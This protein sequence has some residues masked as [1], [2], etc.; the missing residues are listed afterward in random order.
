MQSY[1]NDKE[2]LLK[3]LRRIEGQVKG[4]H[5]MIEN[6]RYCNDILV[7]IAAVRSAINKVG[8]IVLE[9]H[10]KGCV[11]SSLMNENNDDIIDELIDTMIKFI[12]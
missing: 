12:K 1:S 4:I 2:L 6:D 9:N 3:R 10:L 5:K 8:G 7:Q 11:K